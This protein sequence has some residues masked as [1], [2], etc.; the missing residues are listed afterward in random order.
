M[1]RAQ[2][3]QPEVVASWKQSIADGTASERCDDL[4][5]REHERRGIPMRLANAL[6][7]A[8]ERRDPA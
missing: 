6:I 8:T 2:V 1:T 5:R 3:T 7:R 4:I